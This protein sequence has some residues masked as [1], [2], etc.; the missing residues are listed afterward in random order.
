VV[1]EVALMF[2][3]LEVTMHQLEPSEEEE[4]EVWQYVAFGT[5]NTV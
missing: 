4:A 3:Y 5:T 1:A 2:G